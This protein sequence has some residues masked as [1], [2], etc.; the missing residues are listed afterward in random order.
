MASTTPSC[1]LLLLSCVRSRMLAGAMCMCVSRVLVR[2]KDAA[3]LVA[4][5]YHMATI[6]LNRPFA[7]RERIE[8]DRRATRVY[9]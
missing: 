8:R 3:P 4:V 6:S 1:R 5:S 7:K 9:T 2:V